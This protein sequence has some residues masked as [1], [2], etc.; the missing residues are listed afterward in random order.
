MTP[1]P[2]N[3]VVW[4]ARVV[5]MC[6]ALTALCFRQAPGLIVP[7][8]KL[9]LTANPS[10]FLLR[11][12]HLW[13]PHGAFGQLQNQAYG[14]LLPMGPFHWALSSVGIPAWVIQRLWWSLILCVAFVGVWRLARALGIGAPWARFAVALLYAVSPRMLSEVSITSIEV[15]PMAMAPWVLLPL[16]IPSPR[17]WLWRISRSALAFAL[18]GGVNAGATGAAL[19]LP[20]LWFL[21][22]RLDRRT[23]VAGVA[24]LGL[25]M[26]VSL[27]WFLP[28]LQLGRY[29]PPFLDWIESASV[30]TGTASVFESFRGTSP[31]LGFLAGPAGPSWPAGW[32]FVTLPLLIVGTTVVATA[33]LVGL[34]L[35]S[36]PHRRFLTIAAAVGLLLLTLGHSGAAGSPLAGPI[37]DLLDGSLAGLRNTHKFDLVLRLPLMVAAAQALTVGGTRLRALRLP[38]L[39]APVLVS[40]LLVLVTA[41]AIVGGTARPEGYVAIPAHWYQAAAWL[42]HQTSPGTVLVVPA[43]S[44]ADFNWGSTKDDPLQALMRRPFAVRDGVP[45]GSAGSTRLLDEIQGQLG[46]GMGGPRLHA[47]LVRAGVRYVVARNDLRLDAQGDPSIA[48]HQS[49]AQSGIARV[50]EFGPPTGS[51]VDDPT[52]TVDERTLVP[53]PSVE[54]FDVG[55]AQEVSVVPRS[56]LVTATAGPE[57]VGGLAEL[58]GVDGAAVLGS[59]SH[60]HKD[61]LAAAPE[62]LTDG[63][64]NREVFFGRATHNTSE[65]LTIDDPGRQH[66]RSRD[67]VS[68]ENAGVTTLRWTGVASVRASSSASDA[69]ATLHLGTAYSPAGAVDGD[70]GTRW[71]S[72]N[73]G[74]AIGEWLEV[75]FTKPLVV[76]SIG[77]ALSTQTFLGAPVRSVAVTTDRGTLSSTVDG[78]GVTQTVKAPVGLTSRLRV[79]VTS[80]SPGRVNGVSIA[81]LSIP[82]VN[83]VSSLKLPSSGQRGVDA[84]VLRDQMPGRSS[85]LHVGDRPLCSASVARPSEESSGLRREFS[86]P[87]TRTYRFS[88]DVLPR[89]GAALEKLLV[90]PNAISASAS[91]R[92]VGAP[93]GRPD[94]AVDNDLST[95]WVASELDLSPWLKLEWPKA[96]RVDGLQLQSDP[97]LAGSRPTRV[98]VQFDSGEVI[99]AAVDAKSYV[100]F[101][102]RSTRS[103]RIGLESAKGVTNIDS[104]TGLRRFLPVG[105]SEV[106]ILGADDLRRGLNLSAQTLVPCGF[107]PTVVIDGIPILTRVQGTAE[108]V[109][110]RQPLRWTACGP[111]ST[112]AATVRTPAATAAGTVVLGPGVHNVVARSTGEFEPLQMS[113]TTSGSAGST[114]TSRPTVSLLRSDPGSMRLTVGERSQESVLTVAQNFSEGW[115]AQD[116]HGTALVPIRL[117]GWKQGWVLPRG[118]ATVVTASFTPDSPYRVG[119]L[120]GLLA[121][122][123][124]AAAVPLSRR[125]PSGRAETEVAVEAK[126]PAALALGCGAVALAFMSGWAGVAVGFVVGGLVFAQSWVLPR[127]SRSPGASIQV[128]TAPL[129]PILIL[130]LG[131]AAGALAAAQP[132]RRGSAGLHSTTVQCVTLL[133][134]GL[135]GVAAIRGRSSSARSSGDGETSNRRSRRPRRMT[136]RSIRR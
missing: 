104:A 79:T 129:I 56:R 101:A 109:M 126:L 113:L 115:V 85:C 78:S 37:Q 68:D 122:L 42:D 32:Q 21:T 58:Y 84:I 1:P 62:V 9:D 55:A 95:G 76:R 41:P 93:E 40:C 88:G 29:S 53:Y 13:D 11:A 100:R 36:T 10:G 26:A 125:R 128:R 102:P 28:L 47:M 52:R 6:I 24:W 54:I 16:V 97:Y 107:G 130:V 105:V 74:E 131:L 124:A 35:R 14:Y 45:L 51:R 82:G 75:S 3:Q 49:L 38:H 66:R 120:V 25:V 57:D 89:D 34:A 31:W 17:S 22:R 134:F 39:L 48:V 108:E 59:D 69:N 18:I 27:W 123:C 133:A 94:A 92:A 2:T 4:R 132:W 61:L 106:R 12:L 135:A 72:G 83:P 116:E 33:G 23:L 117:D 127:I 110:R 15:W 44:F 46:Q 65:V 98:T 86:L 99:V 5:V 77:L 91:S 60:G 50:A 119:L 7:D 81:D 90:N 121:L 67:Y 8:T 73:F 19:I 63:L 111:G 96:R 118:A 87:A 20:T 103:L 71:I 43:A 70:P 114:P 64:R 30:T 112:A 80:L 136:G